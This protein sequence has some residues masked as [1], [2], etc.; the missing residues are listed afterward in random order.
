MGGWWPSKVSVKGLSYRL[1][2]LIDSQKKLTQKM[3]I[4]NWLNLIVTHRK[5]R[6]FFLVKVKVKVWYGMVWYGRGL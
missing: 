4:L 5:V 3:V 1:T 2:F 6:F